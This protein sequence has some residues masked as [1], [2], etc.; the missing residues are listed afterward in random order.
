MLC[1]LGRTHPATA[2]PFCAD[3]L[4]TPQGGLLLQRR[5][6]SQFGLRNADKVNPSF[7]PPHYSHEKFKIIFVC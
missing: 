3:C 4:L 1:C 2:L 7:I 6:T 5:M